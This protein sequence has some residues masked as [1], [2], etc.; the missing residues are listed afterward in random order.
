MSS[1][2]RRSTLGAR[3]LANTC[4]CCLLAVRLL[5]FILVFILCCIPLLSLKLTMHIHVRQVKVILSLILAL[6]PSISSILQDA[7]FFDCA[8][9]VFEACNSSCVQG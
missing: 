6:V 7:V 2:G 4:F 5:V 3:K 8:N 1:R 9:E